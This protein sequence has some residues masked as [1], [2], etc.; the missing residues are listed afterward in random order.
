MYGP[1]EERRGL[2]RIMLNAELGEANVNR[3]LHRL[4]SDL[5]G[6]AK[7][8]TPCEEDDLSPEG[9]ENMARIMEPED[10]AG[11][12]TEESVAVEEV[13]WETI[14]RHRLNHVLCTCGNSGCNEF[15]CERQMGKSLG[16]ERDRDAALAE[17]HM[18][19]RS[20]LRRERAEE[21]DAGDRM[22]GDRFE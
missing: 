4:D 15:E 16:F 3:M 8:V 2:N 14:R 12:P 1:N 21:E 17:D 18:D 22:A 6:M 5:L 11:K 13:D 7:V 19:Y 20:E 9:E 10:L